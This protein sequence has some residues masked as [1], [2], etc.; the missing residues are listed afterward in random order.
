V[1]V[2]FQQSEKE[3]NLRISDDGIGFKL[4]DASTGHFGIAGMRERAT[5]MNAQFSLQT[6]A[7]HG[8]T[9]ELRWSLAP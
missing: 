1:T 3:I 4:Q 8:S 7:S 5:L 2:E 6:Q 9:V